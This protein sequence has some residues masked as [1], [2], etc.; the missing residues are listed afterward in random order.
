MADVLCFLSSLFISFLGVLLI[1]N[2]RTDYCKNEYELPD[3]SEFILA[4]NWERQ[5]AH[6]GIYGLST[7]VYRGGFPTHLSNRLM[8]QNK[9]ASKLT[10]PF[11]NCSIKAVAL[12]LLLLLSGDISLNPGPIRFPCGICEKP[13]RSNQHG[14]QCD[15]CDT[16]SHR[17]C[18]SMLK[19]EYVRLSNSMESWFCKNCILPN[20]T[21]SFFSC[22]DSS[23][24]DSSFGQTEYSGSPVQS[25]GI[26]TST[27]NTINQS[28]GGS[29]SEDQCDIFKELR[30]LKT[31]NHKKPIICHLNINSL[32]HKFNDLKP[33]L[34]DKLCGILVISETKLDETLV[35]I[36]SS[37]RATKWRGKI[38]MLE[39]EALWSST[40]QIFRSGE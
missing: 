34:M 29:D 8:K 18:L 21:D 38:E 15:G 7:V 25:P 6:T 22:S 4:Q 23:S 40:G 28:L 9:A 20:F 17:N 27:D 13:V 11:R 1:L 10:I 3:V 5:H 35:T 16:W 39:G 26:T 24:G 30:D 36:C 37:Q 19:A 33:V 14:L 2:P 31:G 12:P 32:R